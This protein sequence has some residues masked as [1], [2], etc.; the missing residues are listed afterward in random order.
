MCALCVTILERESECERV[1]SH[2]YSA[3]VWWM[4][5][6]LSLN[7]T[8]KIYFNTV[9]LTQLLSD[10]CMLTHKFPDSCISSSEQRWSLPL[11]QK[12]SKWHVTESRELV[13]EFV[14]VW[15]LDAKRTVMESTL[16]FCNYHWDKWEC[17]WFTLASA[18]KCINVQIIIAY[19]VVFKTL[20]IWL[21]HFISSLLW[22]SVAKMALV[23][24]VCFR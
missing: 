21:L 9:F 3:A 12:V 16:H 1:C 22:M 5:Q 11:E 10:S 15:L 2:I 13:K 8:E 18:V 23:W 17:L 4:G 14:Y 19:T 6:C 24:F 20:F 7:H